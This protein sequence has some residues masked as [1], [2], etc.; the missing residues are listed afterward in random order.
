M[1]PEGWITLAIGGAGLMLNVGTLLVGY[2]VLSGTVKALGSRV[3]GLEDE[4]GA[5]NELKVEVGKIATRQD[6]WIEQLKEL[7]ASVRWMR[8]PADYTP[9]P[10]R[11]PKRGPRG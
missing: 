2:G 8:Q 6:M 4:M 10:A 7:N 11:S 5:L 1:N 9:D 3:A